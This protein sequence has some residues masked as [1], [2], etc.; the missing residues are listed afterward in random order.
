MVTVCLTEM[1]AGLTNY[2]ERREG[3]DFAYILAT[4]DYDTWFKV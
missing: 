2:N 1:M 4:S 3:K